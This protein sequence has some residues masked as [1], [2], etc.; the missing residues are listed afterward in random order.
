MPKRSKKTQY[1]FSKKKK[2][3]YSRKRKYHS[4]KRITRKTRKR[5]IYKGGMEDFRTTLG[6]QGMMQVAAE[7]GTSGGGASGGW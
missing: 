4:K 5:K 1:K 2:K 7:V 6:S 3:Q